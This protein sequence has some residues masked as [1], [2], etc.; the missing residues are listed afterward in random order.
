M[1]SLINEITRRWWPFRSG[2]RAR[3]RQHFHAV[4]WLSSYLATGLEGRDLCV[5]SPIGCVRLS[6][7]DVAPGQRHDYDYTYRN[8][9]PDANRQNLSAADSAEAQIR[10]RERPIPA[11]GGLEPGPLRVAR[12]A[13]L[14]SVAPPAVHALVCGHALLAPLPGHCVAEGRVRVVAR[15]RRRV[16]GRHRVPAL[17]V[18]AEVELIL[19]AALAA[20]DGDAVAAGVAPAAVAV[21]R[22]DRALRARG[23]EAAIRAEIGR[24]RRRNCRDGR[25]GRRERRVRARRRR[26]VDERSAIR[27]IAVDALGG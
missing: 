16:R 5:P 17:R 14:R 22:V 4:Q 15:P 12:H 13:L 19:R 9:D 24:R 23:V 20:V 7:D 3:V 18:V 6:D 8:P 1:A 21:R 2:E 27:G 10:L 25:R 11:R 26:A